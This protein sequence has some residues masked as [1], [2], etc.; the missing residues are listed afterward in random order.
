M[1]RLFENK[2]ACFGCGSCA[3]AC[4][5]G[6]I[7]M[8]ADEE[9]FSYPVIDPD[10]C[11]DCG[12]CQTVCPALSEP[13]GCEGRTFAV[14]AEDETLLRA[15]TSGGAFSLLAEQVLAQGGLVCGAV[16]DDAFR[17]RHVLSDDIAPMRKAK[18]VQSD[19]HGI[20]QAVQDAL[21]AGK[22]VLF[23]GTPCQC[24]GILRYF[25]QK[26]EGLLL[27][28]LICRGV[29]SPGLWQDYVAYL[30]K[31]GPLQAYCFRD[32]RTCNDGHTVSFTVGGQER[33]MPMGRDAF[34]R[35]YLKC[36]A[37]R[38]SCYRCP[39]T[40]WEL[41]FDLTIGD[42]WG[43][44]KLCPELA[45][46]KGTSLVIARTEAG[47]ALLEKINGRARVLESTRQAAE[48]P[49]LNEPA[50]ESILRKLLFRDFA[51]KGADGRC[52]IPLILKKYG[53]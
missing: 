8:T 41:P 18:Y 37:L 36:L 11:V 25:G 47:V 26:P 35:L 44:E 10:R 31:D 49:A 7:A 4:S 9:G 20:Y 45:D 28:A 30:E 29:Q 16:F 42:F 39:Y 53:G 40:R 2:A 43:I 3:A 21:S 34:C 15:S 13:K 46:G 52:D 23:T 19:M 24:D 6:A 22:R 51:R 17:V 32:K 50:G 1:I 12:K 33:S 27:A 48:Q 14:R 5:A 38:P